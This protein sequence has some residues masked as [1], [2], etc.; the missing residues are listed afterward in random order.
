MSQAA[1]VVE[2][3]TEDLSTGLEVGRTEWSGKNNN[4][5]NINNNNNLTL[6]YCIVDFLVFST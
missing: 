6:Y 1:S 4:N 5:N 3:T 2:I